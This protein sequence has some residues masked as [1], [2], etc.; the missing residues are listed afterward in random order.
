M[1]GYKVFVKRS[2]FLSVVTP[3]WAGPYFFDKNYPAIRAGAILETEEVCKNKSRAC[4]NGVNF[5]TNKES[6]LHD[7]DFHNTYGWPAEPIRMY[8]IKTLDKVYGP[9]C[10]R[11]GMDNKKRTCKLK[12]VRLIKNPLKEFGHNVA[13]RIGLT[14]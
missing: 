12:L 10:E 1:K 5:W 3:V 4:G 2:T 13:K 6:A 8:E 14:A 9:K 7:Y 11:G